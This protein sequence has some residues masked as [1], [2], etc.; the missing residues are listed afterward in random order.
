MCCVMY[1]IKGFED[2]EQENAFNKGGIYFSV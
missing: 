2:I 1:L